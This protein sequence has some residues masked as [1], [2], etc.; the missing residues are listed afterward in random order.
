MR[1]SSTI[2]PKLRDLYHSYSCTA[3][4]AAA[5]HT[6]LWASERK[7]IGVDE[8]LKLGIWKLVTIRLVCAAAT[9]LSIS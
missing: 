9:R 2:L 8:L 3:P 5:G 6:D 7:D 4:A 1:D